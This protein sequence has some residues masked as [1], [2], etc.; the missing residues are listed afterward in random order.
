MSPLPK[1]SKYN[2]HLRVNL[3]HTALF[4]FHNLTRAEISK[5]C[6][7]I[8]VRIGTVLQYV[9]SETSKQK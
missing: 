5:M 2:C 8:K 7:G 4:T 1:Q 9:C 6:K 3:L